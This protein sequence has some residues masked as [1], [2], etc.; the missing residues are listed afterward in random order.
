ML[1]GFKP[2][3]GVAGALVSNQYGYTGNDRECA[4]L[5]SQHSKFDSVAVADLGAIVD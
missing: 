5:T 1:A 4:A 2:V 3:H